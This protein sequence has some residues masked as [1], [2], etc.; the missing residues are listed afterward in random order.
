MLRIG[1]MTD[2]A[3]IILNA[4][5][6][7][8][9]KPMSAQAISNLTKLPDPTVS[10]IMKILSKGGLVSSTRGA[11]GG[12]K[13]IK[14]GDQLSLLEVVEA[15]EGKVTLVECVDQTHNCSIRDNCNVHGSWNGVNQILRN[16]LA[17][18]SLEDLKQGRANV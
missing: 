14:S 6:E 13:I 11:S 5:A 1:K 4:L 18:C 10:K 15:M 2:Y 16:T 12:Y 7:R 8:P 17:G 3:F 9:C